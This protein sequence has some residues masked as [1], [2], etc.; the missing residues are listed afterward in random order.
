MDSM[1]NVH[2]V[3]DGN[4]NMVAV[5]DDGG[6]EHFVVLVHVDIHRCEKDCDANT[7]EIG[8]INYRFRTY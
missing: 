7:R 4:S 8:L 2:H 6:L 3:V 5:V 1:R